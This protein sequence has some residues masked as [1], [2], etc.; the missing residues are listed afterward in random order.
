MFFITGESADGF[1]A[2]ASYATSGTANNHLVPAVST[3]RPVGPNSDNWVAIAA[4]MS[5]SIAFR[6]GEFAH[7]KLISFGILPRQANVVPLVFRLDE[8]SSSSASL[9][10]L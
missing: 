1:G 2:A 6:S 9:E 7:E 4:S 8:G 3:A 5:T 10:R